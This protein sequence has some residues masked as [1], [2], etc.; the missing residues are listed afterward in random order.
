MDDKYKPMGDLKTRTIE[1][2]SELI[3]I[4]CKVE[5]F[6]WKNHHPTDKNKTPNWQL[7]LDEMDDVKGRL[8]ELQKYIYK[9]YIYPIKD[10]D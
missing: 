2:C 8:F 9:T 10:K 6:G 3:H 1:E 4:L 7:V 5:R